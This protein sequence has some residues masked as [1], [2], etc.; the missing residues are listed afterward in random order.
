[1]KGKNVGGGG[2]GGHAPK[3]SVHYHCIKTAASLTPEM[4]LSDQLT[5]TMLSFILHGSFIYF[6]LSVYV[7]LNQAL[8]T[9]VVRW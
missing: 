9:E 5:S 4:R 2:G 3:V 7:K 6:S 8:M 1:M